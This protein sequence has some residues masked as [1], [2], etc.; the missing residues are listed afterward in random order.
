MGSQPANQKV[1]GSIG[2]LNNAAVS[3]FAEPGLNH[4]QIT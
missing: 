2:K 3:D 1:T 4:S